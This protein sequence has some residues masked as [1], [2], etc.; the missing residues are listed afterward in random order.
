MGE[1]EEEGKDSFPEPP[2]PSASETSVSLYVGGALV[3]RDCINGTYSA[4]HQNMVL[5]SIPSSMLGA[6]R[7]QGLQ[8]V[9]D[10]LLEDT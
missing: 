8:M 3:A 9:R 5:G 1:G 6:G 2:V 10:I 4:P 7:P